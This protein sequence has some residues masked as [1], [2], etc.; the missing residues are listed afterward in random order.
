MI[1][2]VE[3]PTYQN[4]L[5]K[6]RPEKELLI[7][8]PF[9]KKTAL[10][11]LL[12]YYKFEKEEIRL[13]V[14][15]RGNKQ[16]FEGGSS[17][18]EAVDY[19]VELQQK[20]PERVKAKIVSNV[21]MKAYMIDDAK[22]LITSGNLTPRGLMNYGV[23][24]NVEGGIAC[25]DTAALE[26][27]RDYYNRMCASGFDII[28]FV[29]SA[30]Y[31][32]VKKNIE[33][34]EKKPKVSEKNDNFLYSVPKPKEDLEY[35]ETEKE[36]TNYRQFTLI[37]HIVF[38]ENEE[39]LIDSIP[40]LAKPENYLKTLKFMMGNNE[41]AKTL[42]DLAIELGSKGNS[43]ETRGRMASG[44][45]KNLRLLGLAVDQDC[46]RGILPRATDLGKKYVTASK[47]ERLSILKEQSNKLPWM[48]HIRQ[49]KKDNEEA[50]M[51]LILSEYLCGTPYSYTLKTARRYRGTMEYF[52]E[53]NGIK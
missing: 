21:H 28:S 29:G 39:K 4:W 14:V 18:I 44:V 7:C 8:S 10:K 41:S 15:L 32:K 24:A 3:S 1:E 16:D 48:E 22:L 37:N 25:D 2:F 11:R 34:A 20:Y 38:P 30:S 5:Q 26:R 46:V 43:K 6:N 27:F 35:P 53:L 42:D 51:I 23:N 17:D 49:L 52:C 13:E 50:S 12:D 31:T 9:V 36:D 47:E 19:L 33:R 45:L 40:Q